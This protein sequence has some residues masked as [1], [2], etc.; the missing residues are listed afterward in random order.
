MQYRRYE[1]V[2]HKLFQNYRRFHYLM[3]ELLKDLYYIIN[4]I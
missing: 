1:I 2:Q 3:F 4:I